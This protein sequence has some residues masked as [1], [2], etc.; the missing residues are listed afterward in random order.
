MSQNSKRLLIHNVCIVNEGISFDGYVITSGPMIDT[1]GHGSPSP[2]LIVSADSVV[3]GCGRLLLPGVIDTHVH[4]R[5]PGLTHKADM[6]TESRAAVA[7]GVTSFIDMPNTKPPTVSISAVDDKIRRASQVSLANYGFF[8]GATADNLDQLRQADYTR[9]AGVKLF[10][11]SSTGNMLL[12]DDTALDRLFT[13]VDALIA[14]HAE[15][16]ATLRQR[17]QMVIDRYG[18]ELPI[19]FHPVIRNHDVCFRASSRIVEMARRHHHRLH[20]LHASTKEE[21]SL[22]TPGNP[23]DKLITAE[24]CPQYLAFSDEQYP[25]LGSRIKCNPAIKRPA[26]RDAL[27]QAVTYG[28]IDTIATDHAPHLPDEKRGTAL[29]AASGMPMIQHSLTLMIQMA[30]EGIFDIH[31]IVREMCHN[32]ALVFGIDRRGFIR[33]GYY[34]D[35]VLVDNDCEPYTITDAWTLSRCG[36]TPLAGLTVGNKVDLTIV[37]G[38]VTYSDGVVLSTGSAM[39]LHFHHP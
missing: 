29:T 3:D 11:G 13:E 30:D 37:N 36:W 24:T 19:D 22:L 8:I 21:L 6:A 17:R 27:R 33:P 5:D 2:E 18:D 28:L 1:V 15:D 16:E 31:T 7:G 20:L 4:F 12:D 34:A 35:L 23:A 14:V 10:L 26:D 39:P 9:V 25:M 38:A 32:P